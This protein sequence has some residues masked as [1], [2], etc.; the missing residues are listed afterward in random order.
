MHLLEVSICQN[1]TLRS[2]IEL[3]GSIHYWKRPWRTMVSATAGLIIDF[4]GKRG[5][6]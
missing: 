1:Q 4:L 5:S 2:A 6:P 3:K